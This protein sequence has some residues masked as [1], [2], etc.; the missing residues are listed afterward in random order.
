MTKFL[1]FI[2]AITF[3]VSVISQTTDI[4]NI[5]GQLSEIAKTRNGLNEKIRIDISG[6][7][8]YDFITSIAEEHKLNVSVDN[9]LN[10]IVNSNF[11]DVD[12]KDVYLF[13]VQKY[14]LEVT[15]MNGIIAFNKK[16]P[17]VKIEPPKVETPID[18]DYNPE[19]NFLSVKLKNDSLP[20]VAQ[21]ITEIS[22]KNI[23]LAPDIKELKVSAYIL[24]RPF[25]QVMDMLAKS[26]QLTLTIDE[27]GFYFLG[28]DNIEVVN[29]TK[30]R[31]NTK[32]NISKTPQSSGDL[33]VA[34]NPNGYLTVKAYQ[35]D[36]TSIILQAADLLKISYFFYNPMG[37]ETTTLIANEISFDDLLNHI[38]KGKKYTFKK[39]D[40]LYLI[41]EQNTEGLRITELVQLENRTIELVLP[42]LPKALLE[43]VEV[44]EVMELNGIMISGSKPKIQEIKEYLREID[45][46]VP[47]V[48]IEVLIVQYQKSYDIQTGL[49]AIIGDEGKD[50]KTS[51]VLFPST[52]VTLNSSS[53]NNLIDS[54]NGFGIFNLGKVTERFYAN[55]SA[56]ESNSI[57]NVQ[58]TPKIAT[59]S[60]HEASVSIGETNYYF[61]QTNKLIT[62][63]I[64]ENI[65]QSG[66]WKPTEANL[67]VFIKPYVSKDEQVTLNI[68]V[69]K[70]AF[71]GR[72]GEDAPPDKATQRF[73]SLVRVKNNEMILLG[74]LDELDRQNS[75]SGTPFLSRIPVIK[76]FF[77]SKRKSR[78][79]SKLHVFIKPTI[80]Y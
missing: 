29:D 11:F 40:D 48:Q 3:S 52:D 34:L 66:V 17:I 21:K 6:L 23:V 72:A 64:N 32:G 57:I 30:S 47:L 75:G 44:K 71:L 59:L 65:L 2:A 16:K 53:I 49:K 55:L 63:G 1:F 14:D 41:G 45:K 54:F 42:T 69:E 4:K 58:S 51:G 27:N 15:F 60:G 43:N 37:D 5:E 61:E 35:S 20:R 24:N 12:V 33:T 26:N 13:L 73:E 18:I 67:S 8:L 80:V 19:N 25:D 36:L 22:N 62:S 56:L 9:D 78:S 10:Q 38:F 76:W 50:V 46:V 31:R 79:K 7:S 77:S 28:K 39:M 68:N 74:G 70:S